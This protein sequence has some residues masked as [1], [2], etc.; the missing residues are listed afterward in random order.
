M[1]RV[2]LTFIISLLIASCGRRT[3]DLQ[4]SLKT[5]PVKHDSDD[6]AIWLNSEAPANSIIFG[7]DKNTDGAVYAFNLQGE[8]LEDKT[9]RGLKRPNNV[10]VSTGFKLNDSTFTDILV[11]TEREAK[12]VRVYSVPDMKPLDRGGFPV[13]GDATA[14]EHDLPMG[15]AVYHNAEAGEHYLIVGRKSGPKEGYLYQYLLKSD[16]LGVRAEL[17]RKFGAFSGKKEIEAIAVDNELG[18]VYYS[19]EGFGI[20]KYHAD[21]AKGTEEISNFGLKN[22][23]EDI[24]GIAIIKGESGSGMLV[25]SDQQNG[26]FN[27]FDRKTNEYLG[28][29]DLG[30][31]ETDGCDALNAGLGDAFPNGIFVAMSDDKRYYF[32]DLESIQSGLQETNNK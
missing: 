21:P 6:P 25:V 27:F 32:Y 3:P 15:V 8:I 13:F 1:K 20:R 17:T 28:K 4:A 11:F 31:T 12:K 2:L 30:T 26:S 23:R 5:L 7:T 24:E 18:Y 10:D 14:P 22:F 9:I 19:D 29:M 16:S